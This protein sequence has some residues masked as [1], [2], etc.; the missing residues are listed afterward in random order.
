M[1]RYIPELMPLIVEAL[2]DGAAVTKREVAVATLGQVVQ[3][4]GYV[5]CVGSFNFFLSFSFYCELETTSRCL[6]LVNLFDEHIIVKF[7]IHVKLGFFF[8]FFLL[9]K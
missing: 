5:L 1:R 4:T 8:A 7:V 3:S 9:I 6:C 2:L